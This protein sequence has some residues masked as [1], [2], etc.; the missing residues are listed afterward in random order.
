[1]PDSVLIRAGEKT[2]CAGVVITRATASDPCPSQNP[3]E[4]PRLLLWASN[5]LTSAGDDFHNKRKGINSRAATT[6]FTARSPTP[7]V[8]H[9]RPV[10]ANAREKNSAVSDRAQ[11]RRRQ[12]CL[13]PFECRS[14][15]ETQ[16]SASFGRPERRCRSPGNARRCQP[17]ES[18]TANATH[19]AHHAARVARPRAVGQMVTR[20]RKRVHNAP[21]QPIVDRVCTRM[22]EG[23][24]TLPWR[25]R[26]SPR[27][28]V[29]SAFVWFRIWV[30]SLSSA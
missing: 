22:F 17:H 18:A 21:R 23:V 24:T 26:L 29:C 4:D 7:K 5:P 3:R 1:M 16:T 28:R 20:K 2:R 19:H 11:R 30:K 13:P 27:R 14:P 25:R 15:V 12:R 10:P 9:G 8:T 6:P